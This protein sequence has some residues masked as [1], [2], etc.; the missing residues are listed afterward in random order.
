[1]GK[2][3]TYLNDCLIELRRQYGKDEYVAHLLKE[4]KEK[5]I[6]IGSLKSE[7][8]FLNH[9]LKEEKKHEEI[10][11]IA[12]IELQKDE[13]YNKKTKECSEL[14]N[15]VKKLKQIRDK[16]LVEIHVGK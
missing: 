3:G 10:K 13:F 6:E 8:D 14:K 16:L 11:K 15:E 7:I 4:L 5:N 9:E 1:M 2:N 12:L